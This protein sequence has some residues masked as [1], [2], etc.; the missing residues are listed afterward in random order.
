LSLGL[1]LCPL[2]GGAIASNGSWRWIFLCKYVRILI[3]LACS[4]YWYS[5]P[6]GGVGLALIL[7]TMPAHFPH[8]LEV[9]TDQSTSTQT[10]AKIGIFLRKLDLFGAF[11]L[12]TA[13]SFI[14]AALQEGN[15]EYPWSSGM[16]ISFFVISGI[17]WAAFIWWEW[18]VYRQD[19]RVSPVFPWRL[20]SNRFFMGDALYVTP[21]TQVQ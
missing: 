7:F 17:S 13:C 6:A 11:L 18:F 3:D 4:N 16:V 9:S 20:T 10:W 19:S 14:I 1:V 21:L 15:F 5:V 12:L 2:F 8:Q